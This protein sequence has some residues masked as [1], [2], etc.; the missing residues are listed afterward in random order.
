MTLREAD[1]QQAL[2]TWAKTQIGK[3]PEMLWLHH[4]P[5]GGRRD[6]REALSLQCQGVK[7]GILDLCLDVARGGFH[8]LRI[9]LKRPG[10]TCLKPSKE[11]AEYIKF[12]TEQGYATL[13]SNSF[14]EV[15]AFL[16]DYL[17][18]RLVNA[19]A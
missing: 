11:Q 6:S 5:L 12:L 16:I 3:Y 17:E 2:I 13:V 4:V 7:A 1:L 14:D 10:G 9:E 18:G 8:G 19:D 15:K